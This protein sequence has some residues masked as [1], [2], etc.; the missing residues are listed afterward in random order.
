MSRIQSA[1][2]KFKLIV[3]VP[4][5]DDPLR[6]PIIFKVAVQPDGSYRTGVDHQF[7]AG[8]SQAVKDEFLE[9][10]VCHGRNL[11][12]SKHGW[13]AAFLRELLAGAKQA[14]YKVK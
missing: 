8:M 13:L 7:V 6:M 2:D 12:T 10:V 5:L 1:A 9:L 11:D 3:K 4:N 14:D